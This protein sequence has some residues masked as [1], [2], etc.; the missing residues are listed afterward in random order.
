MKLRNK[1]TDAVVKDVNIIK[2][3]EMPTDKIIGVEITFTDED[4]FKN[5]MVYDSLEDFNNEWEDYEEPKEYFWIAS[6][7]GNIQSAEIGS[8][9]RFEK[10]RKEIGNYFETKE[11]AKKTFEKLKAWKRM[12]DKGFKFTGFTH[13]DRGRMDEL[14]IYCQLGECPENIE[15]MEDAHLLFGGE[16]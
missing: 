9:G 2:F 4:G 6:I 1:K 13:K 16:E 5:R 7:T 3:V 8:G 10:Y 11:E 14:E 15:D 12:K